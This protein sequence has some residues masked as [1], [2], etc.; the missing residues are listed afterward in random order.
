MTKREQPSIDPELIHA[1]R[2]DAASG[3]GAGVQ[4]RVFA[5]IENHLAALSVPVAAAAS[6]ATA[7]A[8]SAA[9]APSAPPLLD[10]ASPAAQSLLAS[11]LSKPIGIA[12]MS[13]AVGGAGTYALSEYTQPVK[14]PGDHGA[15]TAPTPATARATAPAPSAIRLS[16]PVQSPEGARPTPTSRNDTARRPVRASALPPNFNPTPVPSATLP[17]GAASLGEQQALLDVARKALA[18]GESRAVLETLSAHS[19][20]YPNSDLVEEREAL[21][22]KALVAAGQYAAARERGARFQQR[23]PSSLLAPSVTAALRSIP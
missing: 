11:A 20:R 7:A 18:Q 4:A 19:R 12:L 16:V 6:T 9:S 21:A 1:L 2:A 22:I 10:V 14:G 23:F 15:A 17:S 5:R 8:R 3:P 13:A